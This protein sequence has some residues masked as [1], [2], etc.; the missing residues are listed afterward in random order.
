MIEG[1]HIVGLLKRGDLSSLGGCRHY[2]DWEIA[3]KEDDCLVKLPSRE[4]YQQVFNKLP[5]VERYVLHDQKLVPFD[6]SLPSQDVRNLKW[7][8]LSSYLPLTPVMAREN[9]DFYDHILLTLEDA[10]AFVE[11]NALLTSLDVFM[12]WIE[13][14]STLRLRPLRYAVSSEDQVL[15]M[16]QPLPP[17]AGASY[18]L[19]DKIFL[20]SGKMMNDAV[21]PDIIYAS[22]NLLKGQLALFNGQDF[23][24]IDQECLLPLTRSGARKLKPSLI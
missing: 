5:F 19:Y 14:A 10:Q 24:I 8:S 1:S 21:H 16:G 3:E 4:E 23:E 11:P 7:F 18:Y 9:E 13:R 2:S 22:L 6:K 12:E 17:I 20:P 15:L